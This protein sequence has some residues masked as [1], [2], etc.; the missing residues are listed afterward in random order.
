MRPPT[1][2]TRLHV[3]G[4]GRLVETTVDFT[5][6]PDP[7]DSLDSARHLKAVGYAAVTAATTDQFGYTVYRLAADRPDKPNLPGWVILV[8]LGLPDQPRARRE[9]WVLCR[10]WPEVLTAM[11]ALKAARP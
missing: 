2:P 11:A 9:A 3:S 5:G 10:D 4:E 6:L 8:H 1:R 7:D